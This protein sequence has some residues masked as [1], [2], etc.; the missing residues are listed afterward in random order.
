VVGDDSER[1]GDVNGTRH[2]VA[3]VEPRLLLSDFLR[4]TLG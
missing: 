3:G 4:D 1:I 2:D